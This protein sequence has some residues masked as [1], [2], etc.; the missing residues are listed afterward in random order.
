M[1]D[2]LLCIQNTICLKYNHTFTADIMA[3]STAFYCAKISKIIWIL[4]K[5]ILGKYSHTTHIHSTIG[6]ADIGNICKVIPITRVMKL[7]SWK[8][9]GYKENG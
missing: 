7:I 6:D 1:L 3:Y 9:I 5:L 4:L 2:M 8:R